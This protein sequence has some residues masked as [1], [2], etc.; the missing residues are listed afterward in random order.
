MFLVNNRS[1]LYTER[2]SAFEYFFGSF[3]YLVFK[4]SLS[5]WRM[6]VCNQEPDLSEKKVLILYFGDGTE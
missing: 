2:E 6:T 4:R 5:L 1:E 3:L